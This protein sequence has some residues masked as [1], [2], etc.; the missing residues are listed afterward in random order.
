MPTT[1]PSTID[2]VRRS[3]YWFDVTPAPTPLPALATTLS[4]DLLVVGGGYTGLWT[5]LLAKEADP[6][7]RVVLLEGHT[8]GHAASGRNGG[9]CSP[10]VSHGLMNGVSR[11]PSEAAAMHRMGLDNLAGIE[12]SLEHYAIDADYRRPGKVSF[13]RT[14]WELDALRA[15]S[16]TSG[17]YGEPSRF[18]P[19]SEVGDWTGSPVYVGGLYLPDYALVDPYKLVLGLRRACLELGVEIHEN[20]A[21]TSIDKT[22]GELIAATTP[23]G[24]VE[25]KRVALATNAFKPLLR[26]L[27]NTTIPV[28]D[29]A[30]VTEPLSDADLESIGWTQDFGLTD[31]SN[32]F[33]Y[34]R[35]TADNRILWGGY[36]AIY[37]Y[38]SSRDEKLLDRPETY[39]RLAANFAATYPQLAHVQFTH[40]WGGMIDSSTRFCMTA[41]TAYGGRVAYATGFTGLG[42]TATRFGAQVMLDQLAG[43]KTERTELAM[44]R[45]PA[46]PFPPEPVRYFGVQATRWSMA[47]E[48]DHGRRN[49]W[50]R[51]LDSIGLGFDS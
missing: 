42:V 19:P 14:T 21:V 16:E 35:K 30:L 44:I 34:Y 13:A 25:A 11:W 26:R 10:S 23:R 43:R 40:G 9:F 22:A 2:G 3:P 4:A 17:R 6:D 7:Q 39:A 50:L 51:L 36:D 20:T 33:H 49:L 12:Q 46:V 8:V 47:R 5:A 32:Q 24:R 48:D 27:T 28:Y 18:I 38:G 45:R 37:H 1:S 31:A 29:Y 41:G 15:Y